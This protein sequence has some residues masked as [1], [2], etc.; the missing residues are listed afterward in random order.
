[1]SA[2]AKPMVHISVDKRGNPKCERCGDVFSSHISDVAKFDMKATAAWMTK[3]KDCKP[4]RYM[5]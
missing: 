4:A 1:V 5:S 3:H 2:A